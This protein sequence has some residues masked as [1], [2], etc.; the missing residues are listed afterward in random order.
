MTQKYCLNTSVVYLFWEG[1]IHKRFLR[2]REAR[3]KDT[4]MHKNFHIYTLRRELFLRVFA[5]KQ[6]QS[7]HYSKKCVLKDLFLCY[8]RYII[9]QCLLELLQREQRRI[10]KFCHKILGQNRVLTPSLRYSIQFFTSL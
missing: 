2:F 3:Q 5:S 6:L 1:R 4:H 10:I 9:Q 8:L 7:F